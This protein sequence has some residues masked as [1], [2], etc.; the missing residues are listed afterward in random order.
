MCPFCGKEIKPKDNHHIYSCKE[1][2]DELSKE[3]I[4]LKYLQYNYGE[5]ILDDVCND[6]L[7]LYSLPMLKEKYK[8]IDSK[9][10]FFLLSLKNIP[11]RSI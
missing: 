7:N 8:N 2:K 3:E 6:Y 10:I 11:K 1:R 5:N 4:K 9:S